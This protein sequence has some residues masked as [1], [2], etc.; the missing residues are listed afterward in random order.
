MWL[1]TFNRTRIIRLNSVENYFLS[2]D[3]K[4]N[5]LKTKNCLKKAVNSI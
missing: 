1:K 5:S 2:N 4:K 3:L